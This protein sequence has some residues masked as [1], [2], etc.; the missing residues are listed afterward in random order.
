M[1]RR[2]ITAQ[3]QAEG[4][5]T[6]IDTYYDRVVKYIPADIVGAWVAAMG[7]I[8][9]ASNIPKNILLWIAF[10]FGVLLTAAWTLRQTAAPKKPPAITQTII[11]T[12][13]FIIWVIA[14]GG[15]FATL[16]FYRPLYG[17]LLLILYTLV[18]AV[19]VPR[20]G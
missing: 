18:V 17:P 16:D 19:V 14:L 5:G 20:E 8:E 1:S 12:G 7:I 11:S 6:K 15:P 2:I 13:A 10:F 3:L 9:S 4:T